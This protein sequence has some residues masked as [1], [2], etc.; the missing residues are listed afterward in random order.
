MENPNFSQFITA[1]NDIVG[2]EGLE[3]EVGSDFLLFEHYVNIQPARN[4]PAPKFS[5]RHN[6]LNESNAF[7][8]VGKNSGGEVV[9]TQAVCTIDLKGD[10]LQEHIS[11]NL[12]AFAMP[13]YSIDE[14]RSH[15]F[16]GPASRLIRG[17]VCYHGELWLKSG[18]DGF[19]GAGMTA[20]LAR[21][22]LAMSLL[23]WSPDYVFGFMPPIAA[24]KGLAAREGYVHA[25]PRSILWSV[26]ERKE[27]V[28]DWI[29]W[30]SR[31]DIRHLMTI[32]P[33]TL[34]RQ[35]E[36]AKRRKQSRSSANKTKAAPKPKTKTRQFT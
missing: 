15:Y 35:L 6:D 33:L 5:T 26:E 4:P 27:L 17:K 32:P 19:R 10:T 28:E 11:C 22:A 3:L 24:C 1:I 23:K 29:V 18:P 14:T 30:M 7:W 36:G 25:Q 21:L 8:I 31:N 16:P 9:H 2:N 20:I 34:F 13:G 12:M